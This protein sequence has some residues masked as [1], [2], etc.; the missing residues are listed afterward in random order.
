MN[1]IPSISEHINEKVINKVIQDNFAALAPAYFTLTSNWFVRAYDHYKDIDK[2]VLIIYLI[3]QDLIYFR[4]N[5]VK[6]NYDTF[7]KDK[8]I[9]INKINISDIS[10]DLGVP[11]E[12]I[13]RKVLELEE[14]KVIK[15]IGKKIF[16][17]R[18]TLYSAK[19]VDT[20]TEVANMLHEFN[21]IL[22]KEKLL[23]E[24]YSVKEI[25]LAIKENFSY[26]LY[27][28]N[29]FWFI[30]INRWRTELKDLEYLA[31]GM[32]VIINAVKNKE[33]SPKKNMRSYHK[34]LMG[35]DAR[36]VNAMSIS[37]ITGIPRPT[38]V[39]KLKYLIDK[40]YLHINEKK[41][42]SFNAKDSAFIT[43]KGMV[44]K[45]MI[46]LSN[47]IYKVFNQIRIINT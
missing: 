17:V 12:S 43:T 39:R 36:G 27:Q 41:L 15:R 42:I 46:S 44:N 9:E 28:F 20:L 31:I 24:V 1:T 5:G 35:S 23:N 6:I 2:F 30:Y 37:E 22:K 7:Y 19:A 40:K 18:D 38:V 10:K 21:K 45:N 26:C 16:V 47:F 33:F 4:Q 13:R 8:S 32:V 14:K 25:I 34:S 11:K 3:H 29:K